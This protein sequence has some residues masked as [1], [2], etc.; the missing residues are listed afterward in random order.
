MHS[1][2]DRKLAAHPILTFMFQEHLFSICDQE[3]WRRYLPANCS[4]FGS[5]GY[6]RICEAFR[7]CSPR[8]YV[9]ESGGQAICY[10][11]LLR[12]LAELPF[13]ADTTAKWDSTTPDFTGP[14]LFGDDVELAAAFP[15]LR[16]GLF[17]GQGI[18]AE[19]AHLHPWSNGS[20]WLQEGRAYNREIVWV[21]VTLDPERLWR[22]H[23]EHSC[24]KN[25]SRAEKEGVTI[26][27]GSTDDH[28]H[29]FFRIYRATMDRN[30]ALPGYYFSREFFHA[31]RDELPENS[32]F[33]LAQ[34]QGQIVAA[35]LYLHDDCDVFSFLGGADAAFQHVRPTNAVIWETIRWAHAAGKKR[36]I[37]GGGYRA[38]DGIFRFKSTF[39]R[40]RQP[41]Y[42]YRQIHL[43]PDYAGLEQHCRKHYGL[44]DSPIDY[45]PSYR[46]QPNGAPPVLECTT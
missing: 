46:H 24:R 33:V 29:E 10:P 2:F 44:D 31:F 39:S 40:L 41:F 25:I 30:E 23:F 38:D 34:Y 9:V 7:N 19:F 5:W 45:F 3:P 35:T 12:S 28:L 8:L 27:V 42:I 14:M 37:L 11:F 43:R 18:V 13:R 21:D 1:A 22:E 36:L 16:N 32:R 4:V 26:L 20:A 17:R 15:E 6:A